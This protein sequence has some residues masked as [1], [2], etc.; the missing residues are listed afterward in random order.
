MTS[1]FPTQISDYVT[2]YLWTA[3]KEMMTK[4]RQSE[5]T[6]PQF[7]FHR[8]SFIPNTMDLPERCF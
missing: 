8:A 7:T 3:H 6:R 2:L 4:G 5:Q 1:K